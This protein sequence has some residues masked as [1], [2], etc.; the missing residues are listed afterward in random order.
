MHKNFPWLK[1]ILECVHTWCA[2]EPSLLKLSIIHFMG[3][4][5]FLVTFVHSQFISCFLI[6]IISCYYIQVMFMLSFYFLYFS[7]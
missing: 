7:V 5:D 6:Q 2:M 4:E 1:L 3:K